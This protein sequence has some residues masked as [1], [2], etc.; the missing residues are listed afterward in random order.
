MASSDCVLIIVKRYDSDSFFLPNSD[1]DGNLT[2]RKFDSEKFNYSIQ[3]D[4][5]SKLKLLF[6]CDHNSKLKLNC[7][8]C[9][10]GK[11]NERLLVF[12]DSRNPLCWIRV[13]LNLSRDD[14]PL[15]SFFWIRGP[16]YYWVILRV[17]VLLSLLVLSWLDPMHCSEHCSG[18][19]REQIDSYNLILLKC[20]RIPNNP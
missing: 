16:V 7:Q 13:F 9:H 6:N 8:M 11:K 10:R 1:F 19:T 20:L 2:R 15:R 5:N 3:C 14:D 18:T 17:S 4:H 12:I